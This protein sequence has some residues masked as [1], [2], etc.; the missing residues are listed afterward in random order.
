MFCVCACRFYDDIYLGCRVSYGL[1]ITIALTCMCS[2]C[3]RDRAR[4]RTHL[5]L[6]LSSIIYLSIYLSLLS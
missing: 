2:M 4:A 1:A 3:A 6:S 5:G